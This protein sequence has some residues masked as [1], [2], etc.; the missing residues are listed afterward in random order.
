VTRYAPSLA[1]ALFACTV[2]LMGLSA[3]GD[4][5]DAEVVTADASWLRIS[6]RVRVL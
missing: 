3:A 4:A 2:L 1:V 6:P 5:L